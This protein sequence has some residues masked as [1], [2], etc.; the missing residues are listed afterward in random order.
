MAAGMALTMAIRSAMG[1]VPWAPPP[2]TAI[3]ILTGILAYFLGLG[4]FK[5]WLPWAIGAPGTEEGAVHGEHGEEHHAP[6]WTRYFSFN[7]NHKVI[8]IQY[9]VTSLTFMAFAGALAMMMRLQLA[10]PE[11]NFLSANSFN[12]FMSV[13]GIMMLLMVNI[14][15]ITGLMNYLIPLMIGAKDMAF[16]RLNAITFW[17]V[18]PAGLLM[19]S[20]LLAGGFDTGWTAYPP[21][22]AKAPLGMQLMFLG[23]YLAGLSSIFGAVNIITTISKLRAPGMKLF[24]MP[25]FIWTSLATTILQVG[26]TQ[27]IAMSFLLVVLERLLGMGFFNPDLGG[28]AV[29][30]QHLFWFYSHPAVY[31]FVLPGL[32][33][34]SELV[35]VFSRKT[36]FGY[37]G[38]ALAAI[39]IALA[40][41]IVWG[42]HM[43]VAGMSEELRYTFM[44]TTLIVAVPTG[45]KIFSWLATM[46]Q[47]RIWLTT[48]MLFTITAIFVFLIGGL[49]GIPLAIVPVDMHLTDTYFVVAHFHYTLFGGFVF[50]LMAALYYWFP[51]VT[52]RLMN[53]VWGNIHWALMTVGFLMLTL[54]QFE[55]GLLGMRRR[56]A[57]YEAIPG[58]GDL[59]LI[60]TVG[61]LMIGTSMLI[62][63]YNVI[64]SAIAGE[65]A[66]KN[67]WGARTLEWELPSPPP[68]ENFEQPPVVVGTP[69]PYGIPG[70]VHARLA[71]T[72]AGGGAAAQLDLEP[73]REA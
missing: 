11:N 22:S 58:W 13:H 55:L 4:A 10:S 61:A 3:G 24:R 51:K 47:G 33:L 38:V 26:F 60:S 72:G 35:S 43:F 29:L 40:G 73:G 56:V 44:F 46:W 54:P 5:P 17:L 31:I 41:S 48:P 18:P 2:V 65:V 8:G 1:W 20:S 34:I 36:L 59:N 27:F 70:A 42:H 66:A 28:N 7:T 57:G 45:V 63:L 30:F 53:K 68:E 69:Y 21:L 16:P 52:G 32:G 23:A 67:P 14:P 64:H 9:L 12:S 25:I 50:P 71:G 6:R 62:A 19:I 49:T 39:G 15:A 37:K